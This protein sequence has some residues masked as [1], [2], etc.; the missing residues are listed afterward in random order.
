MADE[1]TVKIEVQVV[2]GNMRDIFNIGSQSIDQAAV[3]GP[4][5]GYFTLGT[6]EE[7]IA[8]GELSTKG[9]CV[10]QNLDATNFIRFGFSTGVYGGKLLAGEACAFRLNTTSLF[11]IADT[12]ACKVLVKGYEN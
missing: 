4:T 9:W 3:G 6:S 11:M 2:N 12:A 10:I 1:I 7:T 8:F 5:P